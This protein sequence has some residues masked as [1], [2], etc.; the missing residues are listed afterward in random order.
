MTDQQTKIHRE[1]GF[2]HWRWQR[3]SALVT[4]VLM[5]YFTYMMA[6]IGVMDFAAARA[7]VA[8]PVHAVALALLAGV[9]VLHAALGVQMIIEDYVTPDQGRIRLVMM[10]RGLFALLAIASLAAIGRVAGVF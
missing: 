5:I 2:G 7:F 8:T 10:T 9:G 6:Q 3:I 4:L 1:T